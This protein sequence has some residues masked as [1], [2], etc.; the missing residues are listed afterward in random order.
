MLKCW[1]SGAHS[2]HRTR[3]QNVWLQAG[4]AAFPC[5]LP[6]HE[7]IARQDRVGMHLPLTGERT[8]APKGNMPQIPQLK[9]PDV[10]LEGMSP[11]GVLA[12]VI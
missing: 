7:V 10:R 4:S 2:D 11:S 6:A 1:N 12:F 8:E 5:A 9:V 3:Y